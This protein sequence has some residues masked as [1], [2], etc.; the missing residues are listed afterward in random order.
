MKT[1]PRFRSRLAP[2][3][4][5]LG[6]LHA[7][8]WARMFAIIPILFAC[9]CLKT[10]ADAYIAKFERTYTPRG[11]A[12]LTISN[13][14]GS[15]SVT[16]WDKK[17]ITV[18]ANAASSVSIE[19][20][21]RGDE[22]KVSVKRNFRIGRADFEASVPADTSVSVKNLMGRIELRGV[23]GHLS[24]DSF[25]SEVRLYD[26]RGPSADVKVTSGDIIFDG[27]LR[28]GGSYNF[29]SVKGD[30]DVSI[31]AATSFN[32]VTRAMSENINLGDFL[33]SLTG[34]NRGDKGI[35]GTHL[36]G[37][38]RLSLTTYNGR[39]LLHRK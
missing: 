12:H 36:R 26:I 9:F 25:D 21:V 11:Q 22:I 37:G 15:I 10:G 2:A 1:V 14:N 33:S 30:I 38:A 20:E 39:I 19:D 34:L 5:G 8:R 13:M 28:E 29:Q 27:D 7:R 35:S 18:R 3:A 32:L 23:N 24:V 4:P 6:D 17:T 31:P 16:A